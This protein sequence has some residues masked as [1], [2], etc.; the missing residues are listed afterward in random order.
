MSNETNKS[1]IIAKYFENISFT[2]VR[3]EQNILPTP[4]STLFTSSEIRKEYEL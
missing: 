4:M 3:P 1:E 2:N